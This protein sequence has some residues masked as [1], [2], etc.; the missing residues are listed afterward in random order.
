M[1]VLLLRVSV[2]MNALLHFLELSEV[3]SLEVSEE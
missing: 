3:C 2:K 1:A